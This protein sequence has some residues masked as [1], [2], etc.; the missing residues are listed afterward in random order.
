MI[1]S[2]GYS[3]NQFIF[4]WSTTANQMYRIQYTTNLVQNVWADLGDAIIA[5]G[6]SASVSNT[7]SNLQM[8]YRASLIPQ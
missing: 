8:F 3:G 7:V 4:T 1:L 6:S 2:A 5:T